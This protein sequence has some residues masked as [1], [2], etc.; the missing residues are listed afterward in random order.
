MMKRIISEEERFPIYTLDERDE[1]EEK[2]A[3]GGSVQEVELADDEV[4]A[5]KKANEMF[6]STQEMLRKKFEAAFSLEVQ[7]DKAAPPKEKE[8]PFGFKPGG[9]LIF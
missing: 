5:I 8:R 1:A 4:K 3:V 2:P 7:K 9:D 6:E